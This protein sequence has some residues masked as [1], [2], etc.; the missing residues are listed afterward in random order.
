MHTPHTPA[1]T[2]GQTVKFAVPN[3]PD[4]ETERF[5]VLELR[6]DRVLVEFIC[7]MR[8]KPTSVYLVTDM[9]AQ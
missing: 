3:S 8:I 1:H 6:G 7:D 9:V 4:E 5:I 2:V